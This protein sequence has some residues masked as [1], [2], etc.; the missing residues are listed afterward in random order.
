MLLCCLISKFS[1]KI[2]FL[3]LYQP[4]VSNSICHPFALTISASRDLIT[5]LRETISPCSD[6]IWA[7]LSSTT[8]QL[9]VVTLGL[10]PHLVA[11]VWGDC[12]EGG[13]YIKAG[14]AVPAAPGDV[15]DVVVISCIL[16]LKELFVVFKAAKKTAV[17]FTFLL[18]CSITLESCKAFEV[19]L[20]KLLW[21]CMGPKIP[22]SAK[23][24]WAASKL[25]SSL[26]LAG[27]L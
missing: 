26:R 14:C 25:A 18:T 24:F 13:E 11:M 23:Y 20:I 19:F 15:G 4:I 21:P 12:G 2:K 5:S 3:F 10:K 7:S 17:F 9:C 16:R 27:E 1:H 6:L 22:L 8:I